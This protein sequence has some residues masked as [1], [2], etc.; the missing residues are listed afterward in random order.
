MPSRAKSAGRTSASFSA[1]ERIHGHTFRWIWSSGPVKGSTHEHVFND[2]GSVIWSCIAGPG[3]GHSS[4]EKKYAAEKITD[5]VY[6]VSYLSSTGYTLTVAMNFA[7]H[8]LIGFAS[9]GKG[10]KDWHPCRGTFEQV[11]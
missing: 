3:K 11:R 8:S 10:G 5:D 6:V 7:D 1:D 4:R 9:G 2:D